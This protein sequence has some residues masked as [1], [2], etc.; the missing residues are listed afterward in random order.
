METPSKS[1]TLTD[2]EREERMDKMTAGQDQLA[3]EALQNQPVVGGISTEQAEKDA[4]ADADSKPDPAEDRDLASEIEDGLKEI[5][6]DELI[7]DAMA[8]ESGNELPDS[9]AG[10]PLYKCHKTVEAFKI[11]G[12]E[13][14]SNGQICLVGDGVRM[15]V[16]SAYVDKHRPQVGGYYVKY[17]DGYQSW[18]PA[19]AFEDGYS[20]A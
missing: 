4:Q 5:L 20:I 9:G 18:L 11:L 1:E 7:V 12:T 19:K 2:E 6:E 10:L 13:S 16:E 3:A 15:I 14:M 8:G 17:H